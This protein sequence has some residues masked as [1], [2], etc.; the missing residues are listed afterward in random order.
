ML[1]KEI[2]VEKKFRYIWLKTVNDVDL[3]QHCAKCL[4][5]QYDPRINNKISNL[6]NIELNDDD[7]YYL[8]GVSEPY[9]WN[10]NFHLAFKYKKDSIIN[11]SNNGISIVIENAKKLPID[12][13]YNDKNNININNKA[14]ST[15]RNWQFANYFQSK[16][17]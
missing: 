4:I 10:N 9:N 5:G 15:C 16:I 7:I 11:Y 8:C 1:I 3:S 12:K 14:F 6:Y 13:K 17:K 2:K